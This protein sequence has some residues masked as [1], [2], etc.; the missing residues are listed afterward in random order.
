MP[1]FPKI[2]I[3]YLSYHCQPYLARAYEAISKLNY[4]K[5]N[6]ALIIVD[7]LHPQQGSSESF[8]RTITTATPPE[9]PL[10]KRG[11][12]TVILPQTVNLGYA[13]G[14]NVGIRWTLTNGFDYIYLHNQDGFMAPDCLTEA[15]KTMES[16]ANIGAVQSMVML[17]PQ[18]DLINT[19]GN[20]YHF[21]GFGYSGDYKKPSLVPR[22]SSIEIG[23]ASGAGV[24][25]RADLL[26]QHGLLDAD[27][28]AYHEDLE[29]SLRLR[30]LGYTIEVAPQSV[31]YHEYEFQRNPQKIFYM[32]RNRWAVLIMY[33]RAL[34]W[35]LIAP[36][37]IITE[38][39][40][41][42]YALATGALK[43]KLTAYQYFLIG[44]N[45][46]LWFNKRREIQ[47]HRLVGDKQLLHA[48]VGK[49]ELKDLNGPLVMVGNLFL[50]LYWDIIRLFI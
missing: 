45:R 29:Y 16:H 41:L 40:T 35:I 48:A 24:L 20:K 9:P 30:S 1:N 26:E 7:N 18:T 50:N 46:S 34:T 36:V 39:G 21:L 8:I 49:L 37:L 42:V 12:A 2:A 47:K 22:P 10:G 27:L 43:Q 3:V 13:E 14:N 15:V 31:F 11:T 32:E 25:L 5:E 33:Y 4:P 6:L 23:Y 28:F 19:S 17:Y 44:K 38:L